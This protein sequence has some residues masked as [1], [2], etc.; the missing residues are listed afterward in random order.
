MNNTT[1]RRNFVKQASLAAFSG[2]ALTALSGFTGASI[3]APVPPENINIIGPRDG[4]TPHVGS[5]LSMMD[6]MRYVMLQAVKG[7]NTEQLDFLLDENANSIGAMLFH[8]AATDKWY[9]LNTF[10]GV[11][12]NRIEK[13]DKFKDFRVAMELGD[14]AR[15]KI[16][17]NNLSYYEEIL[18]STREETRREFAKRDDGWLME[19]DEQFWGGANNYCKWFHVCE[20]ESNH[21]GQIKLIKSRIA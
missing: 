17:G 9:Q 12:P 15:K 2:S 13:H 8:L 3:M 14:E 18:E 6:W 20:H 7:M 16:K 5:L 1:N 4:Y 21:N 10:D 19:V 11:E